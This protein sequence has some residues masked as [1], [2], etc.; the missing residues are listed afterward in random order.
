MLLTRL[1]GLSSKSNVCEQFAIFLRL[2][3]NQI[4]LVFSMFSDSLFAASHAATLLISC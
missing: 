4:Y 2:E 3:S 1:I